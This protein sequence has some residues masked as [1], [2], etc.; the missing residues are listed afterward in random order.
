MEAPRG[1]PHHL[2]GS[3]AHPA[4]GRED[5]CCHLVEETCVAQLP[6]GAAEP[7]LPAPR[8]PRPTS[9]GTLLAS[10]VYLPTGFLLFLGRLC[11]WT[12]WPHGR[13]PHLCG[14]CGLS[15]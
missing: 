8:P 2:A 5:G 12:L 14:L 11:A 9:I 3:R 10:G 7:R 15:K 1:P 13:T 6:T 4:G